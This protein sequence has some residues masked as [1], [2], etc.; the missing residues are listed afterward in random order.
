MSEYPFGKCPKCAVSPTYCNIEQETWLYCETHRV[1]WKAGIGL[2]SSWKDE[3]LDDWR[4]NEVMLLDMR[5]IEPEYP[6]KSPRQATHRRP[7]F[8]PF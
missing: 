3:T 6:E 8:T 1:K 7:P 5:E 4:R 2:F